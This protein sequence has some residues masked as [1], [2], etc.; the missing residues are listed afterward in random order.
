MKPITLRTKIN[1]KYRLDLTLISQFKNTKINEIKDMEVLYG[2]KVCRLR[3]IFTITGDDSDNIV[4][5]SSN[6]LIDNIGKFFTGETITIH[7][8]VGHCVG[9]E[10]K[11]GLLTVY[12]NTLDY[13]ASGMQNGI[14]KVF[15]SCGNYLCG[16][17][18]HK[19]EGMT[20]GTIYVS[21]NVGDHA[22][23]RIRRGTIVIDGDIGDH[24]CI[25]MISGTIVI[26]GKIGK[27][28]GEKI[29]RGTVIIKDK[30]FTKKYKKSYGCTYNFFPFFAKELNSLLDKKII[31]SNVKFDR[32][33]CHKDENNLSEIF[34]ISN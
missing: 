21:G 26:K 10:M 29:K 33:S 14:I 30:K 13:S 24:S 7:G 11:K 15:G 2:N 6:H 20:D 31:K 32:Y 12:G 18:N 27:Y 23:Q 22:L 4:I 9:S 3:D 17:P 28:F 5:K 34:V 25:E 8:N 16:K 1:L 19:N